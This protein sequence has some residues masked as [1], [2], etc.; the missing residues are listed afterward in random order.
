M[1]DSGRAKTKVGGE[2]KERRIVMCSSGK[3]KDT[4][5]MI[6]TPRVL[7]I[8][9]PPREAGDSH[10]LQQMK[11]WRLKAIRL[12]SRADRTVLKF[13][14][15]SRPLPTAHLYNVVHPPS[16]LIPQKGSVAWL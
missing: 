2:C 14:Q 12:L 3:P 15:A 6:I 1:G 16:V 7:C 13:R 10:P 11:R 9:I 4:E 5:D 8:P